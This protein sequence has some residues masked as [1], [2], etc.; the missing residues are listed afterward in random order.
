M[1]AY[2]YDDGFDI[3]DRFF[4]TRPIRRLTRWRADV[5]ARQ[6]GMY[7]WEMAAFD[8][9][10]TEQAFKSDAFRQSMAWG[11]RELQ[12]AL[13]EADGFDARYGT[14]TGG[15]DPATCYVPTLPRAFDAIMKAIPMKHEEWTFI[16]LGCGRGR[17]IL[18]ASDY[19]FKRCLGVEWA[20]KH[21]TAAQQNFVRYKNPNQRC[22]ALECIQADAT[23]FDYPRGDLFIWLYNPFFTKVHEAV[24]ARLKEQQ[25]AGRRVLL[26]YH[27]Q[28]CGDVYEKSDFLHRWG[29]QGGPCT[30]PLVVKDGVYPWSAYA[31]F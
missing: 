31:N 12:L 11:P 1:E 23:P 17:A 24:L 16:D 6:L 3:E 28:E 27:Q 7:D 30:I 22:T 15:V 21:V 13:D 18:L 29:Q 26:V 8:P 5:V 14:D 9:L 20:E 19:P 10:M 2:L 4:R 25:T